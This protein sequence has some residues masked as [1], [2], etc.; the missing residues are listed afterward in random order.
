MTLKNASALQ[1]LQAI[2]AGNSLFSNLDIHF[3]NFMTNLAKTNSA[4]VG[5]AAALVS[6]RTGEGNICINLAEF[7][8][9]AFPSPLLGKT[10]EPFV[11]PA[12]SNWT[13]H[14]MESG[15]V[16]QGE[17]N[18]PLVLDRGGRL[19]LRRY[20]EYEKSIIRF[21]QERAEKVTPDINYPGLARDVQ[22]LFTTPVSGKTDWQKIA[23]I[24]AVTRS[25]CVISGG[26]GTGKTSTVSKILVLLLGQY[27]NKQ[28]LR[29]ILGGPT[30]KAASR[31]Q[32]AISS[33]GLL[34]NLIDI[35]QATTLHRMLGPI[36]HS[37]Y[38]RHNSKNPLAADIIVIDE[39]SMVD[40]PL[41]AKLMQAVPD[42]ARLILLGDRHQLASVQP[43]SV[44][45]D[46]CNPEVMNTFT[47]AFSQKISEI[48]GQSLPSASTCSRKGLSA[49]MQDS[50]VELVDNY[51][52]SDESGIAR[53]SRA[54]K[55]GDE[56]EALE[57]LLADET[58]QVSWSD[59]PGPAELEKKL[60][61]WPGFS[62]Y[63]SMQHTKEADAC[64][65]V[66]DNFRILCGLRRGP[67]GM[68]KINWLLARSLAIAN[69]PLS[70]A[71][72]NQLKQ[73]SH[74]SA[75]Q[76]LMITRNDY[77]LQLYN[78]DVGIIMPDPGVKNGLR[79]FFRGEPG[80]VRDIALPLLPEHETVFAMTVH[81]SQG[82]EFARVLLILPDQDSPLLT[83]ELLYTAITRAREKVEIW[84]SKEIFTAA[85]KRQVTRTSG[86]AEALWRK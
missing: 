69:R 2:L 83:R 56:N 55:N 38:F 57:L 75:G 50:F 13:D 22:K 66:M 54:V 62:Q 84:S 72:S 76:P 46:I 79:C 61:N 36:P 74:F 20:W 44:L 68:E 28:K 11:C 70:R 47:A 17:G 32:E 85:V 45:G 31:L 39:A 12:F 29:I 86:L 80:T 16:G 10:S 73:E 1:E 49:G 81:K 51:R 78:G 35:P 19:Y 8:G 42:S 24:M 41:M 6:S 53:L 67:F 30:G 52:F 9:T 60:L 26:P 21:I 5:L 65:A 7:A 25:F 59:I 63:A 77:N 14:L 27:A 43:G 4:D 33:T 64:F 34:Q 71:S 40:L 3:A 23:A 82:S 18:T 15:L 37:P 48:T 58:N